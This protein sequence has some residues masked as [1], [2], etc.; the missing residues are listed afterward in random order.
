M[1][2]PSLIKTFVA[3]GVG[4]ACLVLIGHPLDTIKVMLQ[5]QPKPAPGM[6]QLYTSA[7]DCA[8]KTTRN[9]G[10]PGLY[11]GML[12]PLLGAT[13][14]NAIMFLGYG[15]GKKIQQ[16]SPSD[17]LTVPQLGLAG[18]LSGFIA[19]AVTVPVERVKC[20]MQVQRSRGGVKTYSNSLVCGIQLYRKGGLRGVYRGTVITWMRD[21]PGLALYF[22]SYEVFIRWLTESGRMSRKDLNP[23]Y[24]MAAGGLAGV[25]NWC[26]GIVPDTLK[27]RIQTVQDGQ[28][29]GIFDVYR[30]LVRSEGYGALFKGI[31]PVMLRAIPA[32]AACFLG[33]EVAIRLLDRL[34]PNI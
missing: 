20:V 25:V 32:N 27:S 15:F 12:S 21:V 19:T 18:G 28:H 7:W 3:G 2:E 4:G 5:T 26:Y 24:V 16:S 30:T 8:V 29:K 17:V 31:G 9:E 11:R 33:F 10:I 13:P 22:G 34:F 14:I 23:V 1:T 6:P